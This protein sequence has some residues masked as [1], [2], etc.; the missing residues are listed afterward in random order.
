MERLSIYELARLY[1]KVKGEL[2][3]SDPDIYRLDILQFEDKLFNKLRL[4][5]ERLKK[6]KF[7]FF[8]RK[9][10]E[11]PCR[12]I[13]YPH[14][15]KSVKSNGIE[16]I[17]NS[18]K[19]QL[20]KIRQ[21]TLSIRKI[22]YA[23]IEVHIF[24]AFW[25]EKIGIIIDNNF[26]KEI[27][28]GRLKKD[29]Q[30]DTCNGVSDSRKINKA[31]PGIF[32]PYYYKYSEWR[33]NALKTISKFNKE[34]DILILTLDISNFYPNIDLDRCEHLVLNLIKTEVRK[35]KE[36]K[37]LIEINNNFFQLIRK[38]NEQSNSKG[39]PIGLLSSP[40]LANLYMK[41]FDEFII[42][43]VKPLFYGRYI[44]DI[45]LILKSDFYK[46]EEL[47]N[48]ENILENIL[49]FKKE[50]EKDNEKKKYY[51]VFTDEITNTKEVKIEINP[52]KQRNFLLSK[53]ATPSIVRAIQREI[54]ELSSLRKLMPDFLDTN[55]KL[56]DKVFQIYA[57]GEFG[58]NFR[59][60]DQVK[61]V[62]TIMLPMI[63]C[64]NFS[65]ASGFPRL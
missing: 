36:V 11:C 12:C 26:P 24:T 1:R 59:K 44:D 8:I 29:L 49:K 16:L 31:Y 27:Y 60:V 5:R 51:Y 14:S 45:I 34:Y 9:L 30:F 28:G 46:I 25:I 42:K 21:G 48:I 52:D 64:S 55:S 15:F 43:E 63:N 62:A 65:F 47:E 20:N 6:E 53:D 39:L 10:E 7:D 3:N 33:E 19:F 54:N 56:L 23:P 4:I 57:E 13:Y 35:E 58:D 40:I 32:I 22:F 18:R 17:T 41:E 37:K 2:C 50:K 61:A 38:W